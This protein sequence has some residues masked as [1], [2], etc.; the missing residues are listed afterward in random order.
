MTA[1]DGRCWR[2]W[3]M[4]DVEHWR[5]VERL[6]AQGPRSVA[7]LLAELA[8]QLDAHDEVTEL[9][10]RYIGLGSDHLKA[11]GAHRMPSAPIH[12]APPDPGWP[13]TGADTAPPDTG[14]LPVLTGTST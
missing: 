11:A 14:W 2:Q 3:L 1:R 8:D 10:E 13:A 7:E 5:R 12:A 6:V 4:Y 9:L